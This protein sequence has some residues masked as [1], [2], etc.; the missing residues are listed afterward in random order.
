MS[1]FGYFFSNYGIFIILLV[2]MFALMIIPQR[3]RDK[4]VKA[5]LAALKQ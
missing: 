3:R 5:M 4:K 2:A 1:G